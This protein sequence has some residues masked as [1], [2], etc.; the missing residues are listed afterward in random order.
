EGGA[1]TTGAEQVD[2]RQGWEDHAAPATVEGA[3]SARI[4]ALP[5]RAVNVLQTASV[6]GQVV[7]LPLLVAVA[8]DV[9]V[10]SAL[11]Q[12]EAAGF[13]MSLPSSEEVTFHHALVRE[14]AYARLL[15]RHRRELHRKVAAAIELHYGSGDEYLDLL[16]RHHYLGQT[17]QAVELLVRA[18]TRAARLFAN[19]EAIIHFSHAVSVCEAD[20]ALSA[21]LPDLR[22]ALADLHELVGSYDDALRLY[23]EVRSSIVDVRAWRGA[24]ATLRQQGRLPEALALL[25]TALALP[26]LDEAGQAALWLERG[27]TILTEGHYHEALAPLRNGLGL[28]AEP[29]VRGH[30]LMQM[31]RAELGEGRAEAALR[32]AVEAHATLAE[33]QDS[34]GLSTALRILGDTYAGCGRLD[35]AADALAQGLALSERAGI[36]E[37]VGACL[38]NLGLV[39]LQRGRLEEAMSADRRAIVEFGRVGNLGGLATAYANL[40]EKTLAAGD[41]EDALSKVDR[42]LALAQEIDASDTLAD[43]TLTRSAILLAS[44]RTAEAAATAER[45]ADLL[46][47]I[48]LTSFVPQAW[49]VASSAYEAL[50]DV[51]RAEQ[52]R[53]AA[54]S[55]G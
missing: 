53:A 25:E 16:A 12:L 48:G 35:D 28:Q 6:I 50:G 34:R 31:A 15:R 26:D 54:A 5:R 33:L 1:L 44:G 30:L 2:L 19:E 37:E 29:R 11:P 20:P 4:D 24:A 45:A 21:R 8:G 14:V 43:A 52:A 3:L 27:R 47:A 17:A 23:D 18:A 36:V 46:T 10:R 22:L 32:H 55:L 7:Q 40:A 41:A 9:A 39:D 49:K 42:A 38:I 13:L 51:S